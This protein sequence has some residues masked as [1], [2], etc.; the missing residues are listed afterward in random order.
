MGEIMAG[1]LTAGTEQPSE[2]ADGAATATA[3]PAPM[4]DLPV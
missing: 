2:G 4:I 1:N 3:S